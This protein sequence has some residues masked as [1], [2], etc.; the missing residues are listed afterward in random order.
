[1]SGHQEKGRIAVLGAGTWG[2]VL[3]S[4]LARKG[5]RA[6]AWDIAEPLIE[7]LRTRREHPKLPGFRVPDALDLCT[8]LGQALGEPESPEAVVVVAPSHAVRALCQSCRAFPGAL[9]ALWVVCSKGIEEQTLLPMTDVVGDVLGAERGQRAVVLSGPSHAEE[10]AQAMPTTVCAAA[11]LPEH[12][13]RVQALF[14]TDAFRVYTHD[15]VLG[16]ELGGALKN[17][18]AIAAGVL[19]GMELGD[20][21][22]AALVTRGLAEIVR[23]GTAMGARSETFSGLTGLGDLVVTCASRHSRNHRFGELL[24]RGRSRHEALEEIGMVVEGIRTVRS[25]VALAE[26]HGVDMPITQ[27]V[28]AAIYEDK[29]PAQ[30]LRDLM[31]REPRPEID[32]TR[33]A[34]R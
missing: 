28:Y 6:A 24:A 18:I 17:V 23:L 14:N 32:P 2:I 20:N 9:E 34:G 1:M 30:A 26:R 19:D 12:A 5:L 3:A 16:A 31:H 15:D 4:L 8:D 10:V 21:A 29:S 11:R 13:R 25:A 7:Q 33:R 27:E 22:R